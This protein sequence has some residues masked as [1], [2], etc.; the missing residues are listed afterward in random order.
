V[1]VQTALPISSHIDW[2]LPNLKLDVIHT[3]HPVILGQVAAHKAK[4]LNLP[5]VF[6]FHTQYQEYTHYVPL[7]QD[8]VQDFLKETIHDW[9]QNYMRKCQHIVVPSPSML[10]ILQNE[11]GLDSNYTVVPTGIDLEPFQKADGSA[12]RAKH[13]WE[14]SAVM[15]SIGRLSK[16]KNWEFL[17]KAAA[18][19]MQKHPDLRVVLLG[20]GPQR[21]YLE[22]CADDLSI[23]G[24]VDFIGYIPFEQ[25]PGYLKAAD[26]FGFAST[27][28]TQGLVTLEAL[29][30]GL[31]VVAVDASGTR[32]IVQ[33]GVQGILV[34]Q[35]IQAFSN[36]IDQ[37]LVNQDRYQNFKHEACAQA[38]KYEI[39]IQAERL[40]EIY[41]QA[42][43][44]KKKG[45]FV[46]VRDL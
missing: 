20:D 19:A 23:R 40:L 21:K 29:A 37:L 15:I 3:Q 5:L 25:V 12:I 26:F 10:D 38:G 34:D 16:E 24:K 6:T 17:L 4:K 11:Y 43:E 27:A 41:R 7:P 30:A 8:V 35:D 33:N 13:R 31:P 9:L 39:R 46:K 14:N 45:Q 42:M 22:R 1:D 32:D 18:L 2:L 36:A 28:E 44:E